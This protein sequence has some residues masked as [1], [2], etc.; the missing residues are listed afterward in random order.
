M[1]Q[2]YQARHIDLSTM[3]AIKV[4]NT[5][6]TQ[7]DDAIE[8]FKREARTAAKL[9]HPNTVRVF[10]YGVAEKTCYL[11][12]ECLEGETLRKRLRIISRCL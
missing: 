11:I 9:D 12:M 5:Y 7:D 1:G 4:L 10:D 2:V 6:W 3:V 8:R